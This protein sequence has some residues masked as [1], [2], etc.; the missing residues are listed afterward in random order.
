M[1]SSARI[2]LLVENNAYPF[3]VRVRREAHALR[4]AGHDVSVISPRGPG[5][6][7]VENLDGVAV[8]RFPAPPSASG[9]FG[10][11]FEFGYA[12]FAMFLL[13]IWVFTRRG[14]DVIHAAN[15]PDTLFVIGAFF[16]CFG[17][18]F[19]FDHH[20]IA[21]ETYLSRFNK[22]EN[23]I[24]RALRGLER[25]SYAV[26]N[27]VIATN[28][29]YRQ[30]AL[31]RGGKRS[32]QVFIVRNGPS[33][34]FC[35]LPPD[36]ALKARAKHIVGYIGTMGPQDGVDYW[37]RAIHHMVYTLERRDF[38]AVLI[39]SGDAM[40]SLIRLAQDLRIEPFVWFTGRIPDVEA[41]TILSTA[42]ACIHPDPLNA[43][44][45]RS[46]MNKMMEYMALAKPTASFD[47]KEARFSAGDAAIYAQ[48]NDEADFAR[49][50]CWLLDN[51]SDGER[52]GRIGM[53]RVA[54][55][56]A[57]EHSV[58]ELLRAYE[59]GLGFAGRRNNR[60][61]A[62]GVTEER[63]AGARQ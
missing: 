20:D 7:W 26:A 11:V 43:L 13:T 32:E 14:L 16:R 4:D 50:V 19:V 17:V 57:W 25:C 36:P 42:T 51:P 37:L 63:P 38:L 59:V 47:L 9:L 28:E 33:I 44:N 29:S 55:R 12:T 39:G 41:R 56:L 54:D 60:P 5:Q 24:S 8:F 34:D 49:K 52:M 3:D 45:D 58:P 18:K 40:E 22:Q 2:A 53:R 61:A 27:V 48:P 62:P 10:Y 6:S 1:G 35:A 46:T 31:E 15:P 21:P 30:L 23:L